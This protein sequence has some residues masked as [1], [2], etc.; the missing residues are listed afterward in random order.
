MAQSCVISS[1]ED[2]LEFHVFNHFQILSN[3]MHIQ[4][5]HYSWKLQECNLGCVH[6]VCQSGAGDTDGGFEKIIPKRG[7]LIFIA[8]NWGIPNFCKG[9]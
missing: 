8:K 4:G 6:H 9:K 7:I 1:F 5:G 2:C 3:N